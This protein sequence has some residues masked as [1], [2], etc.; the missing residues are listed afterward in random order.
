[1]AS[2]V[3]R[4]QELRSLS[5]GNWHHPSWGTFEHLG[6]KGT[7]ILRPKI[8]FAFNSPLHFFYQAHSAFGVPPHPPFFSFAFVPTEAEWHLI[9]INIFKKNKRALEFN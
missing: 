7:T 8:A 5:C 6:A 4:L 3:G 1:V 9:A 2:L